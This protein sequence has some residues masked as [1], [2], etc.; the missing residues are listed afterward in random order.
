MEETA[1]EAFEREFWQNLPISTQTS[2]VLLLSSF[3]ILKKT[4]KD[5]SILFTFSLDG[6]VF[7]TLHH[8]IN[9]ILS[10]FSKILIDLF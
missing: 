1:N 6:Y 3:H 4:E 9:H 2:F 8:H 5:T 7:I 10:N